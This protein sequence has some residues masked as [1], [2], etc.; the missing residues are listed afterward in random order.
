[1]KGIT[2]N[3]ISSHPTPYYLYDKTILDNIDI[4]TADRIQYSV[5]AVKIVVAKVDDD[6]HDS[7]QNDTDLPYLSVSSGN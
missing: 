1:M 6:Q 7:D 2:L 3:Q 5:S 4:G